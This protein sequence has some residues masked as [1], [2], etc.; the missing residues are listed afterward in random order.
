MDLNNI[1]LEV[2]IFD[3]AL[4]LKPRLLHI[5]P[6]SKQ[7]Y[8]LFAKQNIN[9]ISHRL[10]QSLVGPLPSWAISYSYLNFKYTT[11]FRGV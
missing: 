7:L 8:G 6:R 2:L 10:P 1:M 3:N 4:S 11:V 5:G 9:P